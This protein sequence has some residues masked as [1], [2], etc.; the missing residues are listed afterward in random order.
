MDLMS[1]HD[2]GGDDSQMCDTALQRYLCDFRAELR[3]GVL[4]CRGCGQIRE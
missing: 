4:E 2:G 1:N 3:D